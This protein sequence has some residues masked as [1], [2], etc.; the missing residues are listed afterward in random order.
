MRMPA[1]PIVTRELS[2]RVRG[3]GSTIV[4]MV[5]LVLVG[6]VAIIA[7]EAERST[8]TGPFD[9]VTATESAQIG[10]T[11]FDWTLLLVLVLIHFVVPALAAGAIAGER[12]RRT[13]TSLQLTLLRPRSIVLGKLVSSIAYVV[14]LAVATIPVLAIGY[15]IGG[16]DV[17]DL[18]RA[19]LAIVGTAFVLGSVAILCSAV[20]TRVQVA[21]VAAYAIV[22]VMTLGSLAAYSAVAI[23]DDRDGD[24][25]VDPPAALLYAA[26]IA[27]V[28]DLLVDADGTDDGPLGALA[29]LT[30]SDDGENGN[31]W[32][33]STVVL[34]IVSVISLALATRRVTTPARGEP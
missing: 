29:S 9:P 7:Y 32:P 12:E 31:F 27:T 16:V 19:A 2:V 21:T 13:L 28:A 10:R 3:W 17:G 34:G 30:E 18:A 8:S 5:F 1:N 11:I 20:A 33:V 25:P 15:L 6:A 4:M 23:L 26:P 24:D 22:V 14:L